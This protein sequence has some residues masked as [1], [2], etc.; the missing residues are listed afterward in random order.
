MVLVHIHKHD[1]FYSYG[2]L[3]DSGS[4]D[5]QVKKRV[6]FQKI[7]LKGKKALA[8]VTVFHNDGNGT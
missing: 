6:K 2:P 3:L 5:G 8:K 4:F 1:E 7:C